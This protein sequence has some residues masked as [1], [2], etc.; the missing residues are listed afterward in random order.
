VT[1]NVPTPAEVAN[2]LLVRCDTLAAMSS[3]P[4]GICRVYLSPEHKQANALVLEWMTAA[5]MTARL[6]AAG[7]VRGHY[8]GSTADAKTLVI[9]SHLDSVPDAGAY[10]GIL[11]VVLGI[12][13]VEALHNA[14][15]R[16]PFAI[17][18][19]GFGEEEG[20]RFGTTLM[21]SRAVA[22]TWDDEWWSLVDADGVSLSEAFN[23]FGLDPEAIESAALK[24][25]ELLAYVEAHIEQGPVLEEAGC[26][27]GVVT[28]IAGAKRLLVEIAGQAGHAGTTPMALRKDALVAAA[29]GVMLAEQLAQQHALV[30]TV[31]QISVSPGGVN[32]IP[33]MAAF[34]LDIRSGDDAVRDAA[35]AEWRQNLSALCETRHLS[36]TVTETH[37]APAVPCADWLQETMAQALKDLGE[38][39]MHL[40]SGAGHDA[41]AMADICDVAMLFI[42]CT[43]GISHNPAEAVLAADVARAYSALARFV[44]R[45]GNQGTSD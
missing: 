31:G 36:L 20:V 16:L 44:D 22:G 34:S 21:G 14:E 10:D 6:D 13:V 26:P 1:D 4:G 37:S 28:A 8:P 7:N 12:A 2:R 40:P 45:L 39:T 38:P 27:L 30:A 3:M 33:G 17:E 41:M 35:L 43:G 15:Q 23:E 9:G 11:G 24:R 32:V 42:R 25:S 19:V 18:V 5:G 29:H